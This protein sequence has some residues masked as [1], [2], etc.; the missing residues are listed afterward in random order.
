MGWEPAGTTVLPTL[1]ALLQIKA[2]STNDPFLPEEF[3][4][5]HRQQVY[6][7]VTDNKSYTYFKAECLQPPQVIEHLK[8]LDL[9]S[10]D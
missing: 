6:Q 7:T 9:E 1:E 3:L 5:D 8:T 2:S 4:W 10:K